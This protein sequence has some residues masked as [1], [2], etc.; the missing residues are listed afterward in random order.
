VTPA[1]VALTAVKRAEAGDGLALRLVE[2]EGRAVSAELFSHWFLRGAFET[3][4][5]ERNEQPL[6]TEGDLLKL[7]FRPF[8]IKTV[9]LRGWGY[10][11]LR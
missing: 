4:L 8:E 1:S 11:P 2:T 9:V 10:A 3:N 7:E 6:T 5:L